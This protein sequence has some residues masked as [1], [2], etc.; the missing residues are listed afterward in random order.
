MYTTFY[1]LTELP[2]E[3]SPNPRYLLLTPRHREALANLQYGISA[4][5]SV[6][7]LIG[8]AGTGKTTLVQAALQSQPCRGARIVHLANPMLN[9]EEFIEFL[10]RAFQL[11]SDARHSKATLLAE[12]EREL[13]ARLDEG[14]TTALVIDEAQCLSVGLL[15]EVRLLSNI[16]TPGQKLL[17]IVLAGQPEFAERLNFPSLVQLKQRVAL[18]C[19]L[20]L[21]DAAETA[22][23]VSGRMRIAGSKGHEIF[24]RAAIAAIYERSGGVPRTISVI[25]DN[26]LVSGFAAGATSIDAGVIHEVCDDFELGTPPVRVA[27]KVRPAPQ[28]PPVPVRPDPSRTVSQAPAEGLFAHY[29]KRRGFSFF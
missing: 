27:D 17:P 29:R 20:G 3:L 6:T 22:G 10:A 1:G 18:R 11:S 23:Y 28:T 14:V 9:R 13:L 21:L 12:L 16:E 5:K 7:L 15:E 19:T 2:F 24:T 26:A 8:A 25:C 4:R